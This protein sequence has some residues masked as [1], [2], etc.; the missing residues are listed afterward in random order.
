MKYAFALIAIILV[1]VSAEVANVGGPVAG[2]VTMGLAGLATY[3]AIHR[4]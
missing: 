4:R 3:R 1:V 2:M